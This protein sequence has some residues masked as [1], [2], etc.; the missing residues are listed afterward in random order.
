MKKF[1]LIL[2]LILGLILIASLFFFDQTQEE[3]TLETYL[4]K[5]AVA[6]NEITDLDRL[7]EEA[8]GKKLVLLGEASHGTHEYYKW[9]AEISKRLIKE[10][11]FNFILVEGDFASLYEL[12]KYVKGFEGA[13]SSALD[14]LGSTDRWPQWMWG[15]HETLELAQWLKEYNEKLPIEKRVGFYGMDVYDEW[16]S[17]RSIIDSLRDSYPPFY[18]KIKELYSCFFAYEDDSWEY[19]VAVRNGADDCSDESRKVVK[20]INENRTS[21]SSLNDHGYFYLLQNSFVVKHAEKFYRKSVAGMRSE[22]WNA[23]AVHMHKSSKRLLEL[24]GD[25]S[26]GIVWAHNTHIGD[27]LYTEMRQVNQ[28][29]IGQKSREHFGKE[30]VFLVG[31][32][33][34]KGEVQAGSR[35][36]SRREVMTIP[37]AQSNSIEE[38]L[39]RTGISSF[40]LIFDQED[41]EHEELKKPIGNRAVGVVYNPQADF[42]QYVPTIIPMRYDALVFFS[43]TKALNP[44]SL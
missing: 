14:V 26:K 11:S 33:T 34:Y 28:V 27:A 30:N 5:K 12:N 25:G 38:I 18:E 13:P 4:A 32:T 24:Y 44:I 22:S 16:R 6:L 39:Q 35:W 41:R 37:E 23:R 40:Y 1:F 2:P 36:G 7:I 17:K 20:I 3:L 15:N 10:K 42:R 9:R 43:E 19:A 8:S 29:N 31:F 21:F